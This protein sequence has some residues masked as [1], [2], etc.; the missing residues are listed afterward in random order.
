MPSNYNAIRRNNRTRF[1]TEI[2]RIGEMLLANRYDD[3]THFIY[4]L[5]QNAEDALSKRPNRTGKRSVRFNLNDDSLIVRHFG[6]P[7]DENDVKSICGIDESTKDITSIG[8]FGIGFKS[9]YAFTQLPEIHSG[10]ED[11]A[12]ENYA[13][14]KS[15]P[16][17]DREHDETVIV[18]PGLNSNDYKEIEDGLARMGPDALIFLKQIK[19]IEWETRN[20]SSGVYLR[21]S[22]NLDDNV[23]RITIVGNAD[24]LSDT[25]PSS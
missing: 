17:F 21:Q 1:G 23:H 5:L 11:F 24:G 18:M 10:D 3:R 4:E 7:F 19:K 12:I 13:W 25:N 8:R 16:Y 2:G 9:V 15:A 22:E 14:P 20:G 6:K